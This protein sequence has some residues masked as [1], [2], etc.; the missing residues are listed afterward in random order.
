VRRTLRELQDR[1]RQRAGRHD[2]SIASVE[3]RY[4]AAVEAAEALVSTR[5]RSR[6]TTVWRTLAAKERICEEIDGAVHGGRGA[7]EGAPE[8]WAGLPALPVAWERKL[9]ARRDAALIAAGDGVAAEAHRA[10][11]EGNAEPRRAILLELEVLLGLESPRELQGERL[12][13]QVKLLSQRFQG[14]AA[15]GATAAGERLVAWCAEPGVADARDRSRC[16][17]AFS[18]MERAR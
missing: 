15:T 3:S 2:P 5:A 6:E 13:L 18:A 16:E 12:A 1:W 7:P 17:R 8:R 14:A 11:I 9:V 10:R 4:K